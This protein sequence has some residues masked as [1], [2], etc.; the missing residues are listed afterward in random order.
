MRFSYVCELGFG[1]EKRRMKGLEKGKPL[2]ESFIKIRKD[3]RRF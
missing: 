3:F 1:E 2:F